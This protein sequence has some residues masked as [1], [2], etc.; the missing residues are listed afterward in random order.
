MS[1]TLAAPLRWGVLG[2]ARIVETGLAPA[3][4]R[5]PRS[6][7]M[8]VASST[9]GKAQKFAERVGANRG[10][11]NYRQLLDDDEVDIVYV[12]LPNSLHREWAIAAL[13][14]GK[15]VLVEKPLALTGADARAMF[16]AAATAD[17]IL[18]EGFM[19]RYHPRVERIREIIRD[20]IGPVKLLRLAYTYDLGSG[21]G[22]DTAAAAR[23]IR[24]SAELGGGALADIGSYTM[25]GLR[26][27]A[28]ARPV[29][30]AG[31]LLAEQ[32][33]VDMRFSGEILFEGGAIGQ[34]YAAMDMPGGAVLDIQ[35]ERGRLRM[36]NAFRTAAEWGDPEI[37]VTPFAAPARLEIVPFADQ[38]ALEVDA[39]VSVLLDGRTP[40]IK[41]E[42]SIENAD[43]LDAVRRSWSE[44]IVDMPRGAER[45]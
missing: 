23:D 32:N 31:R 4:A 38:F 28:G 43:T 41:P 21:Y 29:H 36:A 30:V 3:I 34:F 25:S 37:E 26:T 12:P 14:A 45:E 16:D 8:A 2:S 27:Y 5:D 11:E 24:Y 1:Q 22:D 40:V 15:H 17:K 6:V 19:W 42:D 20:E 7:L 18:L 10:Y 9:S 39:I 13:E 44:H 33:G 35:G